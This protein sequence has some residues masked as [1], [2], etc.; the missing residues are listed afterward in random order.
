MP[1]GAFDRDLQEDQQ[2]I[3]II[4][5]LADGVRDASQTLHDAAQRLRDAVAR[6]RDA[7]ASSTWQAAADEA[8]RQYDKLVEALRGEGVTDPNEYGRLT[9]ETA[10][11]RQRVEKLWIPCRNRVPDCSF[12]R[13]HC[14]KVC[15]TPATK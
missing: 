11:A 15:W 3:S 1:E 5:T 13:R 14:S 7:L 6:Q 9:H 10:I 2:A 12:S 8:D 4:E